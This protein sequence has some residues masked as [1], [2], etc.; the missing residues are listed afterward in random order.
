MT[1]PSA[2]GSAFNATV[3]TGPPDDS[4]DTAVTDEDVSGDG[5]DE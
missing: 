5:L 4:G 2:E 3:Q 1:E